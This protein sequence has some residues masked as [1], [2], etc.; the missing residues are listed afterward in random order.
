M[1][2]GSQITNGIR[3]IV[4]LAASTVFVVT[5]I[6]PAISSFVGFVETHYRVNTVPENVIRAD[7]ESAF[8]TLCPYYAAASTWERW[9][10]RYYW[11]IGW[12]EDYIDRL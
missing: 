7:R 3:G 5:L 1:T 10:N 12:C 9:T 11:N 2:K 8:R 4:L 6:V